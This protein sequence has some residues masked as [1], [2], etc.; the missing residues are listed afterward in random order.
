MTL[1]RLA[2]FGC[3][4]ALAAC[5]AGEREPEPAWARPAADRSGEFSTLSYN[6]AGLPQEISRVAPA[7]NIPL[8]SPLLNAWDV[9]LTQEDFDWWQPGLDRLDFAR[10]HERLREKATHPWRSPRHPG[11][12]AV[13]LFVPTQR[14]FLQVGDGLGLLSRFPFDDVARVPWKSFGP[15]SGDGLA[16]KGFSMARVELAPGVTVDVY[17]LHADAGNDAADAEARTAGYRQLAA[18]VEERSQGRAV[19][20]GGDTNLHTGSDEGD[21]RVWREFLGKTGL[22]DVGEALAWDGRGCIDKFAWRDGGGVVLAPLG[23]AFEAG[24][25]RDG[26]GRPLSDHD[27]LSVRWRWTAAVARE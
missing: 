9:V 10:Y 11:P 26:A 15:G 14:P 23:A 17:N 21:A 7:G 3:L 25:F 6:V 2:P 13:G 12:S 18:F 16:M 22:R 5:T 27:A 8:I 4:L 24:T 19:I 20:L 1:R